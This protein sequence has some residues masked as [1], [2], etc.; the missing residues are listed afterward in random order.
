MSAVAAYEGLEAAEWAWR[1]I[2]SPGQ[3]DKFAS[4]RILESVVIG[5]QGIS[6]WLFTSVNNH[7]KSRKKGSW[8]LPALMETCQDPGNVRGKS[9]GDVAN[10]IQLQAHYLTPAQNAKK[11]K[12]GRAIPAK[13]AQWLTLESG[14]CG[15][16]IGG[17]IAAHAIV[18]FAHISGPISFAEVTIEMKV[19]S[20]EV[21]PTPKIVTQMLYSGSRIDVSGS[22]L[23]VNEKLEREEEL[24]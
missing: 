20:K 15:R 16:I 12:D 1:A 23:T 18:S 6:K 13:P 19:D 14:E 17:S 3:K 11:A 2:W 7:V 5:D 9:T 24:N 21:N 10:I 8:T 22:A 4:M